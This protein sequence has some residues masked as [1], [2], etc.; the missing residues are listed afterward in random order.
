MNLQIHKYWFDIEDKNLIRKWIPISEKDKQ[1][2][3]NDIESYRQFVENRTLTFT[4]TNLV[5]LETWCRL[6]TIVGRSFK[7][8]VGEIIALDQ[9]LRTLSTKY[10]DTI[11]VHKEKVTITLGKLIIRIIDLVN[12]YIYDYSDSKTISWE[13]LFILMP[14]KHNLAYNAIDH[15][16]IMTICSNYNNKFH[17]C[18]YFSNFYSDLCAKYYNNKANIIPKLCSEA[19]F[20]FIEHLAIYEYFD[21]RFFLTDPN[22][23]TIDKLD[24]I[25]LDFVKKN[26]IDSSENICVS[27]SGGVD[28]MVMLYSLS[29]LKYYNLINN[30]VVAIHINY[31]NRIVADDEEKFVCAYCGHLNVGVYTYNINFTKRSSFNRKKYESITR[32]IRFECYRKL[33][34]N[35]SDNVNGKVFLGHIKDDVFE[36]IITNFATNKHISNLAKFKD[37]ELIEGVLIA[38]PFLS[39]YKEHIL[40]YSKK[41]MIPFL[42]NTTPYWS[43]RGKFRNNFVSSFDHQFGVNGKEMVLKSARNISSMGEVLDNMVIIPMTKK[44]IDEDT[45]TI[46]PSLLNNRYIIYCIFEKYFHSKGVAKASQKSINNI[47]DSLPCNK[48]FKIKKNYDLIAEGYILNIRLSSSS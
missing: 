9:F 45:I 29:K 26:V 14:L 36:N 35:N 23:H 30:N 21:R 18:K 24:N 19:N 33:T 12:D 5:D 41:Y 17:D 13:V 42:L 3:L 11:G 32:G 16:T 1:K 40:E 4:N 20:K 39:V 15:K 43:N 28:S 48:R 8:I 34:Q 22:Y 6:N 46:D 37:I 47:L 27:L 38:R 7:F 44:L 31:G 2:A 10:Y 25:I